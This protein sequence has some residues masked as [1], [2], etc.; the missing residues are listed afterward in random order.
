MSSYIHL[1]V[2]VAGQEQ[3]GPDRHIHLDVN[4]VTKPVVS[5]VSV[6]STVKG[7]STPYGRV[8]SA[9]TVHTALTGTGP[10]PRPALTST[11]TVTSLVSVV[12]PKFGALVSSVSV[13]SAVSALVPIT[14]ALT[15][16]V[17]I[18]TTVIGPLPT[19]DTIEPVA[20]L[21]RRMRLPGAIGRAVGEPVP[22]WQATLR[23]RANP[24]AVVAELDEVSALAWQDQLNEPGSASLRLPNDHPALADLAPSDL[25]LIE[26]GGWAAFTLLCREAQR[27]AVAPGEESDQLTT[28]SGPGSL[29]ILEEAVIYPILPLGHW[30]IEEDRLFS[31]PAIDYRDDWWDDAVVMAR[32]DDPT[33]WAEGA[34]I[35]N[36]PAPTDWP[37]PDGTW[38]WDAASTWRWSPAGTVYFRGTFNVPAGVSQLA[39]FLAGDDVAHLYFD[40]ARLAENTWQQDAWR[41]TQ[42]PVAQVSEGLH[43]IG[44]ECANGPPDPAL[45]GDH[46]P[47]GIL[48]TVYGL[49][50]GGVRIEPP[51]FRSDASWVCLARPP[52]PPGMTAGEALLR[53][54]YEAQ[55]RGALTGLV[56]AFDFLVDSDGVPW[57]TLGDV[58]TKVGTDVLTFARELSLTY[59]DFAMA[60]AGLTLYAW[61]RDGRGDV[62]DVAL[63]AATDPTDPNSGNVR[64]LVYKRV[65]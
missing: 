10:V 13:S 42:E 41:A 53:C 35:G 63:R 2:N 47:G 64:Q 31:W 16:L 37:D 55:A 60:P 52:Q 38:I 36:A 54:I 7:A 49:G 8:L 32:W 65:L 21:T 61:V 6:G 62:I 1:D 12:G 58:A 27:V 59:L 20:P 23:H 33:F 48:V 50:P 46:N 26:V 19:P 34:V 11:V 30:P 15:S 24:A 40:G 57:P 17:E 5:V 28:I 39:V 22:P 3:A 9:V 51:L 45:P 4:V 14:A 25:V 43:V 18:G 44:V 29:A 56:C